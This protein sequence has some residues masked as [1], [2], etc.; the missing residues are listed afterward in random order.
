MDTWT[1]SVQHELTPHM[2]AQV[3]YIG[4]SQSHVFSDWT[5]NG[6]NPATGQRQRPNRV[7]GV[8]LYLPHRTTSEWF[9]PAAFSAPANGTWGNAGRNLGRAPGHWQV[10]PAISKRFPLGESRAINFRAEAFNVFNLAQYGT[11]ANT[12]NTA[13]LG[14]IPSSFNTTP[15]GTGTP[16]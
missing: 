15:T 8:P 10:D 13:S 2:T 12:W 4:S 16:R 1:L 5:L 11:P 9:N 14:Q 3:A 7:P 6:T